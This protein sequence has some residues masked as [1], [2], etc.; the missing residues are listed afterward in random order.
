MLGQLRTIL[1]SDKVPVVKETSNKCQTQVV[2]SFVTFFE[3]AVLSQRLKMESSCELCAITNN[4]YL[5]RIA[6][7]WLTVSR[8]AHWNMKLVVQIQWKPTEVPKH[9]H[10]MILKLWQQ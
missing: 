1:T 6:Y 10:D 9:W 5:S 7:Y 4:F 2:W 8:E 3:I